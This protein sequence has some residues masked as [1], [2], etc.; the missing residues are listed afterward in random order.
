MHASNLYRNA[1]F[2]RC[3]INCSQGTRRFP[4][5]ER[6]IVTR[7]QRYDSKGKKIGAINVTIAAIGR[8]SPIARASD[9]AADAKRAIGSRGLISP[10]PANSI[11]VV[12]VWPPLIDPA[13]L[14]HNLSEVFWDCSVCNLVSCASC[15]LIMESATMIILRFCSFIKPLIIRLVRYRIRDHYNRV[16]LICMIA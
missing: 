3:K 16:N 8:S 9:R 13:R 12:L 2:L 7:I 1:H 14:I 6:K 11:R 10:R 4:A 5:S 15:I